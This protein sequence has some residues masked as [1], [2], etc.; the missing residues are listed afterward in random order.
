MLSLNSPPVQLA[1]YRVG[2]CDWMALCHDASQCG[3]CRPF[4]PCDSMNKA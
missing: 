3:W 1:T 2:E 4:K